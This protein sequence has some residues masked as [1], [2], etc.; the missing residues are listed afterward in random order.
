M[1]TLDRTAFPMTGSTR[2]AFVARVM[3]A[4]AAAWKSMKN[5]REIYQLGQLTEAE[6]HD[7][8]LTRADLHVAWRLPM[9]S[10]PTEHLG[11]LAEARA[12][13]DLRHAAERAARQVC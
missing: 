8:G 11:T 5:R 10:D 12:Y 2:P 1:T 9:T 3:T 7:I 13:S 6:L 4:L